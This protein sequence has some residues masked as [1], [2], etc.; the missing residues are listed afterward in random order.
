VTARD[1]TGPDTERLSFPAAHQMTFG[2]SLEGTYCTT[3]GTYRYTVDHQVLR[4][5]AVGHDRC[6]SRVEYLLGHA[7]RFRG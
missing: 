7:W 1:K 2:P 6:Q 4:F 3:S 5:V